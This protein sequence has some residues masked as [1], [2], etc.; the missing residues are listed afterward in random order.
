MIKIKKVEIG[1]ECFESCYF[2]NCDTDSWNEETN[3]AVCTKCAEE[4]DIEDIDI[5]VVEWWNNLSIPEKKK[6]S[7]N[8]KDLSYYE[9]QKLS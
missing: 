4:F 1:E 7:D 5:K 8:Y 6:L 9:I 2:C 3:Q